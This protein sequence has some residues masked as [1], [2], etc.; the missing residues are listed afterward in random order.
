MQYQNINTKAETTTSFWPFTLTGQ[1]ALNIIILYS[2]ILDCIIISYSGQISSQVS[3]LL[4][5]YRKF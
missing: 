2:Y 3:Q 1:T 4:T 5:M